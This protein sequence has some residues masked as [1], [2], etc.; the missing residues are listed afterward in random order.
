MP[1][2]QKPIHPCGKCAFYSD[3]VWQPIDPGSV[4]VLARGFSRK[5]LNEGQSLFKQGDENRGVFC[6]SAGLIALRTLHANGTSTLIRLAYPGEIIGFRSFLGK[7]EH[8]TEARALLP[9]RVCTVVRRDANQIVKGNSAVLMKLASRCISEID[10]N[11]ERIIA[12][13]TK[14]NKHRLAD[15]L[16][17]LMHAHGERAADR[18]TMQ[19]PLSRVDMAD[20][21]GVQPETMSRLVKRLEGGGFFH[22]S[23]REVWIPVPD[24]PSEPENHELSAH[25]FVR[26]RA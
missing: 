7:R 22:F 4:S 12:A 10:Q 19:L 2:V 16:L 20:L 13:A 11:H 24:T 14:S 26:Q 17:R 21:I 15:L 23:G 8:H 5:E 25:C 3:S 6:V 9:S 1:S 18:I